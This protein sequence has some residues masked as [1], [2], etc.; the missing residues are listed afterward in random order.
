MGII[1]R[2]Q[3]CVFG[4]FFNRRQIVRGAVNRLHGVWRRAWLGDLDLAFEI[5]VQDSLKKRKK[6]RIRCD[7]L[8]THDNINNNNNDMHH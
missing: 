1:D 2:Q 4:F 6:G 5:N 7:Q 3:F 8:F